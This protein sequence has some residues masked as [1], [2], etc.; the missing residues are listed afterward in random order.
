M[1]ICGLLLVFVVKGS[2]C[3]AVSVELKPARKLVT[4]YAPIAV[5]GSMATPTLTPMISPPAAAVA[6][7]DLGISASVRYAV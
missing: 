4:T 1:T 3:S 7:S 6:A 5:G 2:M